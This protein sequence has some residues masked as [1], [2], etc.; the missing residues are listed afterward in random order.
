MAK[1]KQLTPLMRQYLDIKSQNEDSVLFFRMGDFYELFYDDAKIASEVLGI[2]LTSRGN[3][4]ASSVPLAGFPHHALDTYLSKM[5]KAGYRVAICDQIEDP[6]LA[7]T[8]VKR[9]VT[10]IVS[11][12]TVLS[13]D[14]LES[15]SNNY[16]CAVCFEKDYVGLA[17]VDIS[18]GE[19][20]TG[21][22]P[23]EKLQDH[24]AL[25]NP[26]E[27]LI[28]EEQKSLIQKKYSNV[29]DAVVTTRDG[30]V[31]SYDF[32][33]EKLTQHFKTLTLKGF[34][35]DDL[36]AGIGAAGAALYYLQENQKSDLQHI[37]TIVRDADDTFVGLDRAT[38]RNLELVR[39]L[40]NTKE[41][42]LISVLDQTE[43]PMGARLLAHWLV[44]PLNKVAAINYRLDAVDELVKKKDK[45]QAIGKNLQGIGDIERI[46]TKVITLRANARDLISLAK[47]L[48]KIQPLK[49]LLQDAEAQALKNEEKSLDSLDSLIDEIH[50]ALVDDPPLA[51]TDGGL[52]RKGYS[53]DL[54]KLRNIAYSGKDWILQLQRSEREKTG[55]PSLKVSFNKVF[56][57]YIEVTKPNLPKVPEHYIRKQTLVNAERFITPELK[58]YEEQIL[59]AE[60]KIVS[61]EYELFNELRQK[62]AG[63][64]AVIQKN[65]ATVAELDCLVSFAELAVT[66]NYCKPKVNEGT[67]LKIVEGRHPVIETL[68]PFGE[69]FIPNDSFID[70]KKSQIHII[71]GPNM[72][73]KST[74]LR[75]VALIVLLAQIGSFV[76]AKSVELGIVDKIFTR[77]GASDNLAAGESTFLVEMNETANILNNATRRSIILLDEIGRGT[78]TYD[79]I[80]IAWAISEYL[81]EHPTRGK[82]LFATHYH[83]L[84]EMTETFPRIKNYNVSVKELKETVLF[85]RKLVPGGSHHSFGIHVAKMAGMPQ[86]VLQRANKILRRLEK[87]HASEEL[88]EEMKAVS[89]EEM[90]L[91]F[92]KLDDPLLEELREEILEIDIDTLTPVEALMKL[93]EIRRMLQRKA[94]VKLKR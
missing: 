78:S 72:A 58:E 61:I 71:T 79:G 40:R 59:G 37:N 45:L 80:S 12:G 77:V 55:I 66:Q 23:V 2:T 41:G 27:I 39:S 33:Y 22:F 35:C 92:F 13:D 29:S 86:A 90:Q 51:I 5:V 75:Q 56:G 20:R 81:H 6:K 68:L 28:A 21:D 10:Q 46:I 24:L 49:S 25:I 82:T 32:A 48:Q 88:T 34:G 15:R 9:A 38:Q 31:F 44:R 4:A 67:D 18:T 17:T 85:L 70:C 19:F 3:G 76:P 7:K 91:S 50:Q 53:D 65:A 14:L 93:N 26:A 36:G 83:E 87:S 94:S 84:N 62:A 11:P 69:K 42:T 54:D 43:T 60:E 64:A 16:L 1:D 74:Y 89:K 52:I 47:S 63:F 30:W 57:Y 73:G 8:I